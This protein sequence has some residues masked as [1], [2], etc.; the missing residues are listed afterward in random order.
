[1][2]KFGDIVENLKEWSEYRY[3]CGDTCKILNSETLIPGHI[4]FSI[5]NLQELFIFLTW[6]KHPVMKIHSD[7]S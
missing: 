6:T 1:M 2:L 5:Q 4:G 7:N 3:L